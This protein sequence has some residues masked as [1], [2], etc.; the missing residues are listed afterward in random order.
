MRKRTELLSV[1]QIT[2]THGLKG[3]VKVFPTTDNPEIRFRELKEVI[4]KTAREDIPVT[5]KSVRFSKNLALLKFEELD[6]IDAVEKYKGAYLCVPRDKA[7][8]LGSDEYY[9]ADLIGMEIVSD[10][11]KKLGVLSKV[12]HTGANDVYEVET[13]PEERK[14]FLIPAI[15]DCVR[16]VDTENGIM[17]IHVMEGLL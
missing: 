5:I 6:G 9:E 11:G 14:S 4:L 7:Q 12:L 17:T 13:D 15:K 1:G 2:S 10:E 3:E 8:K 16:D